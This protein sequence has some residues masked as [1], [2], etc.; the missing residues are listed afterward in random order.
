MEEYTKAYNKY[1]MVHSGENNF[2]T[3]LDK[4]YFQMLKDARIRKK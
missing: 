1:C 3:A 4:I 2:K